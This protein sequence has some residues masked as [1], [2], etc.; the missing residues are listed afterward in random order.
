M[1]FIRQA[2]A[3]KKLQTSRSVQHLADLK[4]VQGLIRNWFDRESRKVQLQSRKDEFVTSEATRIYHHELH[5]QFI[6]K[7]SI[8]KLDT[9]EGLLEGHNKCAQYL[10]KKVRELLCYPADLDKSAQD[11]L[12][13]LVTPVF[14]D[15]DNEMLESLPTSEEILR[16]LSS[17]NLNASAGSDGISSLVYK[18]CWDVLGDSISEV[19]KTLFT[20]S[21]PTTSMRTALMNFCSKP[22][23]VTSI[24][25]GDKRRISILN[26]DFKLYEGLL[27]KCFRKL[28][29][30][31]LS[32]LQFVAGGNR[33]IHHGIAR[34]R[35]AIEAA[36]ML[37]I[38][39]GIGD[40]DYIAAFDF[41]VLKWVWRVL[42]HKG[43]TSITIN[44]LQ[45]LYANG[46][47][48]PV[49]NNIQSQAIKDVRGS[50][51][52]GG[53]GSMEWF[54]FGID[55][56]FHFLDQYLSGIPVSTLPVAGPAEEGEMFPLPPQEERFKAMAFCDDVKPTICS[57]EEF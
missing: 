37:K 11:T 2:Y 30:R 1:L 21:A 39:C 48:I 33:T 9:E 40:Q 26:C 25:P 15:R 51:R 43:V 42:E 44:R 19:I 22:K 4:Y 13:D 41:L 27:A 56:L 45:T 49:I 10:E 23:K 54:A 47:T 8:V 53:A 34:A 35:D 31:V 6:K 17:S 18:E 57:L 16:C 52:Q 46:I 55:P 29:S 5:K 3:V 14:S 38:E 36:L 20:G 12:L 7:S 24:K 32:P 50:L 28:G